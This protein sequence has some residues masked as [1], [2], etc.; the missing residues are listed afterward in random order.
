MDCRGSSAGKSSPRR[1]PGTPIYHPCAARSSISPNERGGPD[2]I[3]VV[4]ARF[5]GD[6]LP[7][8]SEEEGVGYRVYDLPEG[9]ET[10]T[11]ELPVVAEPTPAPARPTL[12]SSR[13]R[14][15]LLI[16]AAICVLAALLAFWL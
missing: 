3:T 6:G 5:T 14:S 2:N 15:I 4:A 7:E 9:E 11:D 12:A 16:I 10:R 8:P 1:W 13:F